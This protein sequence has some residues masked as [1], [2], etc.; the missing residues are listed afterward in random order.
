ML[1]KLTKKNCMLLV[2]ETM[3]WNTLKSLK[4]PHQATNL[5]ATIATIL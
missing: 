1:K 2:A 3:D 5:N 4:L